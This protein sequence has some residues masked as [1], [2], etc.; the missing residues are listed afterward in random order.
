MLFGRLDAVSSVL[1]IGAMWVA[2]EA[3]ERGVGSAFLDRAMLWGRASGAVRAELYVT[4]GNMAAEA[5]YA[6]AGFNERMGV[7]P[8]R[9]GSQLRVVK[10]GR[11][12]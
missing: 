8:L 12:L 4:Q 3:R 1:G 2:P 10:L 5:L 11:S 7:E 9:S 6:A